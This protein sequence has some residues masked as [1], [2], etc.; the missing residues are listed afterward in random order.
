MV[1]FSI[2]E[3]S[4]NKLAERFYGKCYCQFLLFDLGTTFLVF[5]SVL[6]A[7]IIGFSDSSRIKWD[8]TASTPYENVL[9]AT[10]NI[11]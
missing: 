11:F 7:N 4:A 9:H 5:E 1:S 10:E 3:S 6:D 2:E 8:K